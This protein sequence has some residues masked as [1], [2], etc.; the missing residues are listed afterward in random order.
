[1]Y[2]YICGKHSGLA[3][4]GGTSTSSGGRENYSAYKGIHTEITPFDTRDFISGGGRMRMWRSAKGVDISSDTVLTFCFPSIYIYRTTTTLV[5]T[6]VKSS[7]SKLSGHRMIFRC[8]L[9][10]R[11][12]NAFRILCESVTL[13]L[14]LHI[15]GMHKSN[16]RTN[17]LS[18][19]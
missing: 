14:H 7:C 10:A 19:T 13:R 12:S 2:I 1:M 15:P 4:V 3:S 6:V 16:R 11:D 17:K 8:S 18:A 9:M 5:E